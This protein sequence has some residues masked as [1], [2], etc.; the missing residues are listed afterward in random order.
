[1]K[2]KVGSFRKINKID[3]P[4]SK[5]TKRWIKNIKINKIRKEQ[6]KTTDTNKIKRIIR[7][8]F[9]NLYST[10]LEYLKE[11]DNFLDRYHLPKLKLGR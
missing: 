1:M 7:T 4:L 9:K 6:G 2:Q 11:I 5:L 8:Y 10:K 3:K